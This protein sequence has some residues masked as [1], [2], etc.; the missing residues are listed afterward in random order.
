MVSPSYAKLKANRDESRD[1]KSHA[2][3]NTIS[4]TGRQTT[5]LPI[6]LGE[7]L[8]RPSHSRHHHG[9]KTRIYLM[10][11]SQGDRKTRS[12]SQKEECL[13]EEEV[14]TLLKKRGDKT[15]PPRTGTSPQS[16]IPKTEKGRNPKTHCGLKGAKLL[17]PLPPL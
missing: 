1:N 11:K 2:R 12:L 9:S 7:N 4:Q 6:Q 13:M 3:G 8:P 10:P 5:I 15:S 17:H 16:S 14:S